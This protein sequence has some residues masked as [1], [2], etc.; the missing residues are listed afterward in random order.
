MA[1]PPGSQADN[2]SFNNIAGAR[3]LFSSTC[4]NDVENQHNINMKQKQTHTRYTG[5]FGGVSRSGMITLWNVG[6][7]ESKSLDMRYFR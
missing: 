2:Q 4:T 1:R 3:Q 5:D 7:F 6:N